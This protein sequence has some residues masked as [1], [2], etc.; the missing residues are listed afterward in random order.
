MSVPS[1][2]AIEV[3]VT[4]AVARL[5]LSRPD[6]LNAI[7]DAMVD[8]ITVAAAWFDSRPDVRVVVLSG[9]GRMFS[10]GA[11]IE[12]FR[13]RYA[14][15]DR[16]L[17]AESVDGARR[18]EAMTDAVAGLAAVT[19]AAVHGSAVGGAVALLAACD[20]RVVSDDVQVRI[21]ELAMG[22]PLAWGGIPRLVRELGPAVTRDL[23]VTGRALGATEAVQRGW[24]SSAHP[25]GE[26]PAAVADLAARIAGLPARGLRTALTRIT[27][28]ATGLPSD[29]NAL[30]LADALA[31]PD[32]MAAGR[33][34]LAALDTRRSNLGTIR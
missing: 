34:Y 17:W 15:T 1:F 26:L 18:G 19:V 16:D 11:D 32:A 28:V 30:A 14:G 21:P 20:L 31:D 25:A 29:D 6:R 22:I 10:A 5:T 33:A 27:A 12:E 3:S 7:S 8:E 24:A 2:H 23:L 13:E 9:A 4:G